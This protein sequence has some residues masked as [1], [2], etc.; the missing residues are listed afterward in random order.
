[1]GDDAMRCDA[2][3]DTDVRQQKKLKLA[4]TKVV[5]LT[6]LILLSVQAQRHRLI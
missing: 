4:L 2:M 6:A 3:M 5:A 1:M